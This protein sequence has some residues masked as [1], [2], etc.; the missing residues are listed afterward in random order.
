MKENTLIFP[1]RFNRDKNKWDFIYNSWENT[2][3]KM[4]KLITLNTWF[5]DFYFEERFRAITEI[6]RELKADV[7]ALQEITDKSLGIILKEDWV[8]DN[9]FIS[10]ISGSTFSSYGVILLSRIPIKNLNLYPLASIMNRH[11]LIAEFVINE[12]KILI[13]TT[14]LESLNF[15]A[16]IRY[17]QLKN[18]FALLNVSNNSVLMGD[19]NFC[20]SWNENSNIDN[21]YLDFW[22]TLRSDN[23]GYTVYTDINIMRKKSKSGEK[24]V[25]FDRIISRSAKYCWKP[26][27]INRIG[28]KSISPE[29]PDIFPSDHFGLIGLL[30]WCKK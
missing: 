29:C 17:V 27:K 16:P 4:L 13:G 25:R 8:K 19:F 14:H 21:S 12:Q 3:A 23:P 10:D 22:E 1:A 20:S 26:K 30:E 5:D 11:V 6:L 2:N 24:K 15:S 9:Y 28:M 7:I 18:I